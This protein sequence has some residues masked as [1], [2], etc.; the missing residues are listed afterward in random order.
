MTLQELKNKKSELL[1]E[2]R[3]LRDTDLKAAQEKLEEAKNIQ[4]KIVEMENFENQLSE[5]AKNLANTRAFNENNTITNI[6]SK[7]VNIG[8]G[9]VMD[10]LNNEIEPKDESKLYNIAFAK[11]MMGLEL[12][13]EEAE[14]FNKV[15]GEFRNAIQ[16]AEQHTI[17]VPET[18]RQGIWT[19]IGEAHP[20]FGDITP[21]FI[22]GKV[23]IIK[24]DNELSDGEWVDED[25]EGNDDE[26]GFG[27]IELD[28]CELVK[29]IKISWKLKK[30]S[31][32]AFLAYITT[33]LA[34]KMGNAI[35]KA[36]IDGKGKPGNSDDWKSQPKGI[37]TELKAE[38]GTPQVITYTGKITYD[39]M[40]SLMS[41]IKSG[42]I[43]GSSFYANNTTIWNELA[44]I[45]DE[46]GKSIFIPD[47]TIGGVGRIFGVP[48][49]E[50]DGAGDG[51][52]LLGN[53]SK[54]YVMNINENMTIYT[55]DH[56]KARTT[57]YMGYALI[58]GD[59]M[60]TKAFALLKK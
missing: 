37:A 32:D 54:G 45:K 15:N 31:I 6:S 19:E 27:S 36:M 14:T 3:N 57:D 16:T 21:T 51:Q 34:E 58:D 47:A 5:E 12:N 26:A 28:G 52:I 43:N 49:K 9:E 25:T 40:L 2:A 33:K 50:E 55:D 13:K 22:P 10:K 18:V 48:V 35:A 24:E 17:L 42:Y 23:T 39:N 1:N 20:I 7:S 11:N 59:V 60:T 38:S 30:M 41:K 4:N 44:A 46:E 53:V 29:S 8:E 56:V